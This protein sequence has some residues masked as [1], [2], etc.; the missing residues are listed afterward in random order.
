MGYK[1]SLLLR[2]WILL[3]FSGT[4]AHLNKKTFTVVILEFRKRV[5]CVTVL[6]IKLGL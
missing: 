1:K 2:W 4:I 3:K 6:G 5:A